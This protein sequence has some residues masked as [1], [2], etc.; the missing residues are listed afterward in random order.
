[1]RYLRGT[2]EDRRQVRA[3]LAKSRKLIRDIK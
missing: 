1:M 3:I 2:I